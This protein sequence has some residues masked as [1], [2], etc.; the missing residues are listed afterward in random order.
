MASATNLYGIQ[1]LVG[2]SRDRFRLKILPLDTSRARYILNWAS[3]VSRFYWY[4][5]DN[6]DWTSLQV[7]RPD[8]ITVLPGGM[9]FA[10][11]Q[12]W[13]VGASMTQVRQRL[14]ITGPVN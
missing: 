12:Q 4:C 10:T 8:N 2:M 9:A 1:K 13:L 11:I 6:H 7:T 5:W 3:G 14:T